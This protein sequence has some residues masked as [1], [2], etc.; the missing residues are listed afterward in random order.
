M[1]TSLCG[2]KKKGENTITI[3]KDG[4]VRYSDSNHQVVNGYEITINATNENG[5]SITGYYKGTLNY[6]DYAAIYK[7]GRMVSKNKKK[8]LLNR[9]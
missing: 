6:F 2:T 7:S 3:D 8:S 9:Q 1:I 5:K 4:E